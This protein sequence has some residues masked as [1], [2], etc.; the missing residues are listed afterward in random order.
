M[1]CILRHRTQCR[2]SVF[3]YKI[4]DQIYNL[5]MIHRPEPHKRYSYENNFLGHDQKPFSASPLVFLSNFPFETLAVN[6]H[7]SPLVFFSL[8]LSIKSLYLEV[9]RRQTVR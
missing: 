6:S 5:L 2:L 8:F 7:Q 9:V 1:S 4:N 3:G